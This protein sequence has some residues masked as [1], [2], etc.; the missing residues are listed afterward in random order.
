MVKKRAVLFDL[1]GTL[2]L[3]GRSPEEVWRRILE[4]HGIRRSEEEIRRVSNDTLPGVIT[5]FGKM[6]SDEYWVLW[7]AAVLRGLGVEDPDGSL[8]E[9]IR[10]RF[11]TMAEP[12]AYADVLPLLGE[13]RRRGIKLGIVSDSYVQEIEAMLDIAGIPREEFDVIVGVDTIGERK[14][15][16]ANFMRALEEMDVA[17]SDCIFVGDEVIRDGEGARGAGITPYLVVRDEKAASDPRFRTVSSL[18]Q[19]LSILQRQGI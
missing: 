2:I 3:S 7:D 19:V 5:S 8:S 4:E 18:Q 16:P 15:S 10:D 13:L 9:E 14:P 17:P 11:W 1:G 6:P 12:K